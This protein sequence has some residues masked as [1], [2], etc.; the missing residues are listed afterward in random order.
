MFLEVV[1]W[2]FFGELLE[3]VEGKRVKQQNFGFDRPQTKSPPQTNKLLV[4]N[5]LT[6]LTITKLTKLIG[7][8]QNQPFIPQPFIPHLPPDPPP[9]ERASSS[10][11]LAMITRISSK[12]VVWFFL[13][14]ARFAKR[15]SDEEKKK[16]I[17]VGGG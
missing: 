9:N 3:F 15:R 11:K 7:P 4:T 12:V 17:R 13:R 5:Y 16:R 6:N 8:Q 1:F 14:F 2:V 10:E